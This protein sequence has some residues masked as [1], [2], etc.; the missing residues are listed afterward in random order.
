MSD[1]KNP[2]KERNNTCHFSDEEF[3]NFKKVHMNVDGFEKVEKEYKE[4]KKQE[5]KDEMCDVRLTKQYIQREIE[6]NSKH[7]INRL[8]MLKRLIVNDLVHLCVELDD[9]DGKKVLYAPRQTEIKNI[10]FKQRVDNVELSD[11]NIIDIDNWT[12]T[13]NIDKSSLMKCCSANRMMININDKDTRN[14]IKKNVRFTNSK[15]LFFNG[16]NNNKPAISISDYYTNPRKWACEKLSIAG[17]RK[18]A[19]SQLHID[20]DIDNINENL[21]IGTQLHNHND[22]HQL[23]TY[24]TVSEL[25]QTGE[26]D[27]KRGHDG[28]DDEDEDNNKRAAVVEEDDDIEFANIANELDIYFFCN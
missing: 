14:H 7:L 11:V 12:L 8:Q 6:S 3:N 1:D 17:L 2:I 25:K 16:G 20:S 5:N 15:Y 22:K 28:D 19:N 18:Y 23:T 10:V 24:N 9:G 13:I 27:L 26:N 21:S 4:N